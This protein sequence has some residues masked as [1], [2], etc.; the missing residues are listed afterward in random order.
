MSIRAT[1]SFLGEAPAP[2]ATTLY[3][4]L[5]GDPQG[6]AAYFRAMLKA[7]EGAS[8]VAFIR[9]NAG[10]SLVT[11]HDV[12]PCTN[13]RYTLTDD[14]FLLAEERLVDFEEGWKTIFAGNLVDFINNQPGEMLHAAAL[15]EGGRVGF[16]TQSQLADF[17]R[18]ALTK[19]MQAEQQP[20]TPGLSYAQQRVQEL[21]AIHLAAYRLEEFGE[22]VAA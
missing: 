2:A 18:E 7:D 9:A 14:L 1:Y 8:A 5:D 15:F 16:Y 11:G 20:G 17:V 10:A 22:S 21:R 4:Q 6:A 13:Y 12:W 3:I 19:Q